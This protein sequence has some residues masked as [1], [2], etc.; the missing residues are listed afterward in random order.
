MNK[1]RRRRPIESSSL[2][3]RKG[4]QRAITVSS[5]ARSYTAAAP[6]T[7]GACP[8]PAH[9]GL[10][11]MLSLCAQIYGLRGWV[12]ATALPGP[13]AGVDSS[14]TTAWRVLAA[15]WMRKGMRCCQWHREETAKCKPGCRLVSLPFAFGLF[16]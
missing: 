13:G 7:G 4:A 2:G 11:P 14:I 9:L 15:W 5:Q 16:S 6:A 10:R 12:G 8:R 1:T 3:I